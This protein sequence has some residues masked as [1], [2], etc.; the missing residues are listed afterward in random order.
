MYEPENAMKRMPFSATGRERLAAF[1]MYLT[2]FIYIQSLFCAQRSWS[3]WLCGFCVLFVVTAEV[4]FAGR[5]RS[6]ES[7]LW[8]GCMALI[9]LGIVRHD[10]FSASVQTEAAVPQAL[11]VALLHAFGIYWVLCRAGVL[12]GGESSRFL[13]LDAFNGVLR[14]PVQNFFL[15]IRCVSYA[16]THP[17]GQEKRSAAVRAAIAAALLAALV[18]LGISLDNLAQ[19]DAHFSA[20]LGWLRALLNDVDLVN[21]AVKLVLSLPVGA[22]VFGL[23]AGASREQPQTQRQ[24][25]ARID[26]G[27][28]RLTAV[29]AQLYMVLLGLFTA[30]YAAFFVLQAGY[31]FGA[32][33]R[34]LPD[35]YTVAEY[36]RQGFFALCRVMAVN[37]ALLWLVTRTS[38]VPVRESRVLLLGCSALLACSV[39]LAVTALAKLWLYIS[40]FGF[41]PKR[42]Q[43]T[44][45]VCVLLAGCIAW[46]WSLWSGKKSFRA[47]L[48]F[49]GLTLALLCAY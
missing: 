3:I 44:W 25:G 30:V 7:F 9:L 42:L 26:A 35:G 18:L 38:S 48:S 29:P 33:S 14:L 32:F 49:A 37:F 24:R 10:V 36:A 43:S 34:T 47:F 31:L 19:A 4:L 20:A 46:A 17:N 28:K 13:P 6:R 45:L 39:L 2:A 27:L 23:L 16:V 41:T 8:L 12:T 22:Y 1:G 11:A 5:T 15:R 21:A 40:C